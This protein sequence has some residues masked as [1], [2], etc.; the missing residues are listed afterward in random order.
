MEKI[1][2]F[3]RENARIL[4]ALGAVLAFCA[5]L[6]VMFAAT[7]VPT[8]SWGLSFR[9]EGQ[10]PVGNATAGALRQYDA[11]YVGDTEEKVIYL[12]FDAGYEAGYTEQI[13]DVL[14]KHDVKAAFFVVGTYIE[15]N[16][17]L[18]RRMAEEGHIVG[19]HTWHH[20]NMSQIADLQSFTRERRVP[21][22][23]GFGCRRADPAGACG[24]CRMEGRGRRGP[25]CGRDRA[26]AGRTVC[27]AVLRGD[28]RCA[29]GMA[30]ALGRMAQI[31]AAGGV[32]AAAMRRV[33]PRRGKG[34]A[35]HKGA[36]RAVAARARIGCRRDS[37]L[38][39]AASRADGGS[40]VL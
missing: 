24:I 20:Y 40:A 2:R 39:L 16:P 30:A 33:V 12:T 5:V 8:G 17:E 14:K 27:A 34:S 10:P 9:T 31:G 37:G 38:P 36:W 21:G 26:R 35:R 29:A 22:G 19:N 18:V 13:L 25:V 1:K 3:C 23:E 11:V 4:L 7:A 28:R 6:P 15:N 32:P